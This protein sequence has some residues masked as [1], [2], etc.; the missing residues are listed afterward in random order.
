MEKRSSG[1]V[2]PGAAREQL[3]AARQV[4]DASVHRAMAL[5]GFILALSVFC[6]AQTVA[7]A[8]KGPGNVVTIIAVLWFLA[9]LLKS[10]ACNQWR[11]LRS[12]TR[13]KWGVTEVTL[14]SVAVLVGGVVGPHMLASHSNSAV[15]S[16]GLGGAVT[17][18]VAACLFAAKA[19][20]R[21]RASRAWQR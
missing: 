14:I 15:A 17:V 10:S 5:A 2:P 3:R 11:P 16:W 4:H 13:P 12:W 7:P 6:G 21:R 8:Y 1:S 18:I 9:E 19:S 20:Y